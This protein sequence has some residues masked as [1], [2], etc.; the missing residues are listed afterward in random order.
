MDDWNVM[1][2]AD[3]SVLYVDE[4]DGKTLHCGCH[5]IDNMLSYR[6]ENRWYRVAFTDG[7]YAVGVEY[8]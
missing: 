7:V 1:I 6:L 3:E 5:W 8:H 4:E 2:I